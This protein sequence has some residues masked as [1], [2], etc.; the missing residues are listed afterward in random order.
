MIARNAAIAQPHD[1]GD[2][3]SLAR[4]DHASRLGFGHQNADFLIGDLLLGPRLDIQV[5]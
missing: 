3:R 2:H 5:P 4:L 1:P